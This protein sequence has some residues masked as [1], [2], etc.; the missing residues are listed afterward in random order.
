MDFTALLLYGPPGPYLILSLICFGPV[1]ACVH[2]NISQELSL[3]CLN[4]HPLSLL[5]GRLGYRGYS[6]AHK[7]LSS[8]IP[9]APLTVFA[10]KRET[11]LLLAYTVE[12]RKPGALGLKKGLVEGREGYGRR[13][14]RV[15]IC[16]LPQVLVSCRSNHL[17]LTS[18]FSRRDDG[19]GLAG[20]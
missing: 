7:S 13:H 12:T 6:N 9:E 2:L 4:S 15:L 3:C 8:S 16:N 14:S 11:E 17:I 20:S 10:F 18:V 19:T 1:L 5:R